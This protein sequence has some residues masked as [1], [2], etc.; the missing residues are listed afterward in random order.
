MLDQ[1]LLGQIIRFHR[2]KAGLS[3]AA[4]ARL[5]GVGKS[6]I[7]DLEKGKETIQLNTLNKVLSGLNITVKLESQLMNEYFDANR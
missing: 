3:Q 1:P 7:F 6:V 4:F 5:I 2:K